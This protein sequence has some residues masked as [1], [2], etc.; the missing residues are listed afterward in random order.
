MLLFNRITLKFTTLLTILTTSAFAHEGSH[1]IDHAPAGIMGDHLHAEGNWMVGYKFQRTSQSDFQH[2]RRNVSATDL[3]HSYGEVPLKMDMDMHMFDIMYGVNDKLTLMVMPQ[4]MFM[5]MLHQSHGHGGH[6][7][8]HSVE[9]F[10]DTPVMALYS[11]MNQKNETGFQKAHL[12]LGVSLPTGSIDETFTNHHGNTYRLPYNMQFGSGT[13]D[14]I[15]GLT[16]SGKSGA[17]GYGAQTLNTIRLGK[18]NHGYRQGND[19]S[20]N[21]WVAREI[22]PFVSTSLRLE[23]LAWD[24]VSGRDAD[25]PLTSILGANPKQQAGEKIMA[26]VGLNLLATEQLSPLDGNRLTVEFGLPVY[27]RYSGPQP[28]SDYQLTLGWQLAF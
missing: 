4:Y 27:E 12:N 2:N 6:Q 8:E 11:V 10:G 1:P 23:G 16:Y 20:I 5:D 13:V 19:Y 14:P 28:K 17:W 3:L 18:N 15:V 7:H 24:N 9:G 26:H 22:A 25:L 21:G